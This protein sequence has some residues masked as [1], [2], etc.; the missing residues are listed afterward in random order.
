MTEQPPGVVFW[1]R[2]YCVLAALLCALASAFAAGIAA[3]TAGILGMISGLSDDSARVQGT[4]SSLPHPFRFEAT[5][6]M[7]APIVVGVVLVL[8]FAAAPFLRR[9]PAAWTYH[10]VLIGLGLL[11]P[12][13]PFSVALIIFWLQPRTQAYFGRTLTV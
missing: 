4:V 10:A 2:A 5:P 11:T 8:A 6:L 3:L 1:Y 7:V 9:T 12:L 13:L